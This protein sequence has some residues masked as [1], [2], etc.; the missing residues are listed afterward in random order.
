MRILV[1]AIV[2][3]F[4]VDGEA[5]PQADPAPARP[6]FVV[7]I[8]DDAAFMDLGA[9]GG[10][11]RTPSIDALAARGALF[12][13]YY[14][15]PLC[16]PSRAMLLTGMDNHL[17][18][19]ST[20]P[21]VLPREH[22]GQPGYTMRLEPGVATLAERLK[23]LGYRTLMTGKWHLGSGEGDL[24][25]AHGFDRSFALD[26]SGADN[27]EDK[28]YMPYYADAPWYEDD[29]PASLPDDFYSSEFIVDQMMT[30]MDEG[31]AEAPFFAYLAFMAVH[32][33]VQAPPEFTA[34]YAGVYDAGWEA[35]R[36]AR[37]ERAKERGYVPADAALAPMPA[38][39]RPWESLPPEEQKLY[40]ARMQVNAGML[41]AMDHHIGR[42]IEHLKSTGQYDNTV[43]VVTSDNGPEPS[44]GDTDPR[45]KFW[46]DMNGY[47]LD[48][49]GMGEKGSWAFI[50]PEWAMAAASPHDKF[51]F[52]GS[53]GGIRVPFI[54]SGA[55]LGEG[56]R[57]DARA[58]VTDVAP[59]LLALAGG[60]PEQDGAKP[61]TGRSLL[62]LLLGEADSVYGPDDAI[63]IEV[64][65][66]AAVIK[67]DYK[68]TRNQLPHGDA[69]WRL[70]D[71]SRDPGETTDLS[72]SFPEV[73][74]D[75][76][77]EYAA[78]SKRVGV[79]EVP[80][81]YNSLDEVT[82]HSIVRQQERYRPYLI[83]GGLALFALI[84]G[85]LL[86]WRRRKQRA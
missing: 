3:F 73:Y 76:S 57:V 66:N 49:E 51:K 45:L 8:I 38:N 58:F 30:Y 15:S 28:S 50:G 86:L 20:I 60:E 24:P 79:L 5:A 18:G 72:A 77:T 22:E 39:F 68:L 56:G 35:T 64:S 29:V 52:L 26:A 44:R 2:A 17:T 21:E 48:L 62:P 27:W 75:L 13:R 37:W 47:H 82:R 61:M 42:L 25:K 31:D 14:S 36:T 23:P 69:R 85:G 63:V 34:N 9:Y 4:M 81:G 10:E 40:A 65:G 74:D 1:A 84:A 59:T 46:M 19:V 32:I 12:T 43:F 67:G 78:Y 53:E 83:G 80:E 71:L 6:N 7:M 16:S 70:Y 54:M 33:P 55:G 11:A 41:E